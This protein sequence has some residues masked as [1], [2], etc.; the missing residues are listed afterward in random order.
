MCSEKAARKS[1]PTFN[2]IG[3][4]LAWLPKSQRIFADVI[5]DEELNHAHQF[6]KSGDTLV[7]K[8]LSGFEVGRVGWKIAG[9]LAW[10]EWNTS[11]KH[12]DVSLQL[13]AISC[14]SVE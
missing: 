8:T 7:E 12:L 6:W 10:I 5:A 13:S 11:R 4:R 14:G 3:A 1:H 9:A 2:A